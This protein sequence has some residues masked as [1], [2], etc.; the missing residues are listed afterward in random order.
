MDY[1]AYTDLL[2]SVAHPKLKVLAIV[3]V[4]CLIP[5]FFYLRSK[6][7]A[8]AELENLT[9]ICLGIILIFSLMAADKVVPMVK[10]ISGECYLSA[11]G[12]FTTETVPGNG[13]S[14]DLLILITDDGKE[15]VLYYKKYGEYGKDGFVVIPETGGCGTIWYSENAEFVVDYIPDETIGDS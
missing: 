1:S 5:V 4:V 10:D 11:H 12:K 3:I 7:K 13:T 2:W 9:A 6:G 8:S 14:S 15:I